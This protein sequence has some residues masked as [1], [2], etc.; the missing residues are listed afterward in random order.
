MRIAGAAASAALMFLAVGCSAPAPRHVVAAK[1]DFSRP[2]AVSAVPAREVERV[3]IEADELRFAAEYGKMTE[4]GLAACRAG[5]VEALAEIRKDRD[6]LLGSSNRV[7]RSSADVI[8]L[9]NDALESLNSDIA[10]VTERIDHLDRCTT[11]E[12][13]ARRA[14]AKRL[15]KEREDRRLA[16]CREF[17]AVCPESESARLCLI[18]EEMKRKQEAEA[19]AEMEA[20]A[21]PAEGEGAEAE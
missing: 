20:A 15:A 21:A 10:S 18:G 12:R 13:K 17:A 11:P 5:L 4:E 1:A 16:A 6:Y 19:N 7:A 8:A 3:D 14:E 2:R 9:Y